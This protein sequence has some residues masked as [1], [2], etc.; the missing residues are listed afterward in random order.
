MAEISV[1]SNPWKASRRNSSSSPFASS[2]S[3]SLGRNSLELDVV[4]ARE[5]DDGAGDEAD[6]ADDESEDDN[7]TCP[8]RARAMA[9][10]ESGDMPA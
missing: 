3:R 7:T 4:E 6:E 10:D 9:S 8:S 2:S 1:A 5:G